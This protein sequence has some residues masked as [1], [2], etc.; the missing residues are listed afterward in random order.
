MNKWKTSMA[1][2]S[3]VL[4]VLSLT[5]AVTPYGQG[6]SFAR[7]VPTA[8]GPG[9][10][11]TPSPGGSAPAAPTGTPTPS[12]TTSPTSSPTPRPS[13]S[14]TRPHPHK[15]SR[16]HPHKHPRPH[17]HKHPRPHPH[18]HPRPHPKRKPWPVTLVL[19][20]VPPLPGVEFSLDGTR[21]T[22]GPQGT[23]SVTMEHDRTPH[24]LAVLSTNV[25][26]GS[27]HYAFYRWTGQPWPDEA[28]Q[29]TVTALPW[30]ADHTIEVSFA[31]ECKVTPSFTDQNGRAIAP[32]S[33]SSVQV[34][35]QT[36]QD[37][38]LPLSGA[39]WLPCTAPTLT[40]SG[41]QS[42][43]VSYRL[44]E[45]VSEGANIANDGQESFTPVKDAHPI[46]TGYYFNL[47]VQ[48]QDAFLGG[49]AGR[50]VTLTLPDGRTAAARLDAAGQASF[51]HLP[52]ASYSVS[53]TGGGVAMAKTIRL[54][55]DGTVAL[56]MI[57]DDDLG[58]GLL[59]LLLFLL[60][61]FTP[62]AVRAVRRRGTTGPTPGGADPGGA[63]PG[64]DPAGPGPG[65]APVAPTGAG[66]DAEPGA[67]SGAPADAPQAGTEPR[68]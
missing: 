5:A 63:D 15:S 22:V 47:A 68:S 20:T 31:A 37:Y 50:S 65:P 19:R 13:P 27:H 45:L 26:L 30:R 38:R 62:A 28:Y 54:S 43:P 56:R 52:R 1:A 11:P 25:D 14:P 3:G 21:Y 48:V 36:G 41:P 6:V 7:P 60:A 39:A 23:V 55:R 51:E 29:P 58:L 32:A 9:K 33:L 59:C 64:G 57:S 16:P 66:P 44:K 67:D 35:S 4:V 46:L 10:R 24:T 49:S 18:K 8:S 34:Q 40:P 17:P 42:R 12:P 2:A 61:P 53:S